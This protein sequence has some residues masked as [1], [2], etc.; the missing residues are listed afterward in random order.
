MNLKNKIDHHEILKRKGEIKRIFVY[1]VC[2]TGMGA[3]ATLLKERGY[4]VEGGDIKFAPPMGDYLRET[5]IKLHDLNQFDHEY[6]KKFDLIVVG[7][8]VAGTSNEARLIEESGVPFISFPS[9]IGG[10]VLC[11]VN[12]VGVAGTHGKTTTTYFMTQVFKNLG[13]NPGHFIG[14]VIDGMPSSTLGD[15]KYFFIESDEYDSAYFEKISKFRMYE[16]DHLVLTSLEFDHADIFKNIEAIQNEFRAA[17]PRISKSF[18]VNTDYPAASELFME[19]LNAYPE[20]RFISYGSENPTFIHLDDRGSKFLVE[21]KD[22]RIEFTT[23]LVGK[24]NILN[25]TTVILYAL[26][27]G[28]TPEKINSAIKNLLM[29][30]RRQEE[31]GHYHDAL[32]IDDFAHHPRAVTVTIDAIRTRYK[33]KK[34]AVV[35]EPNSATARSSVF[36]K[37]FSESLLLADQVILAKPPRKATISGHTDLDCDRIAR[38]LNSNGKYAKVAVDLF[39]LMN[40]INVVAKKETVLLILSNG[41]CLGLWE[42]EFVKELKK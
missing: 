20:R 32:V 42:S 36:Q 35:I 40:E 41:T 8:V 14:G 27:E 29:V 23:N 24:H 5:G 21:W 6:L 3:T 1:R 38:E 4:H 2:G 28:F 11:D 39:T 34:I 7:N 22:K 9:A 33:G 10:L 12:V 19:A 13:E 26:S 25:L 18:I 17:I 31:R 16:I 37:E 30:K 15:G